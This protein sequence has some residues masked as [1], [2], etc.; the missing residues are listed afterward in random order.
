M[1]WRPTLL[2]LGLLAFLAVADITSTDTKTIRNKYVGNGVGSTG[3]G[4][5]T[6]KKS[7]LQ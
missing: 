7:E 6:L 1:N 3:I 4:L 2:I 5:A